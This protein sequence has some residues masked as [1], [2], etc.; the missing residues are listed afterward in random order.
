MII[1]DVGGSYPRHRL[2]SRARSGQKSKLTLNPPRYW[3]RKTVALLKTLSVASSVLRLAGTYW[4]RY[5]T[6]RT[7]TWPRC[8]S[9]KNPKSKPSSAVAWAAENSA[10]LSQAVTP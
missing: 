5:G 3:L 6:L 1:S 7:T 4:R 10:P 2:V 8:H 9:T